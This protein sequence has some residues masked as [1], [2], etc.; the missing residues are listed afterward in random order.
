MHAI[1][2][3]QA[4]RCEAIL[5]R[6]ISTP[7]F[8]HPPFSSLYSI[9]SYTMKGFLFVSLSFLIF[10]TTYAQY[11]F[12]TCKSQVTSGQF[13]M[14][15][16]TDRNGNPLDPGSN[17][18]AIEGYQYSYCI[19]NCGDGSEYYS[20]DEFASQFTLWLLPWLTLLAQ[21]P[22]STKAL[23]TDPIVMLLSVGSPT[24][25][26]FSLIV[27]MFNRMWLRNKC[28]ELRRIHYIDEADTTLDNIAEVMYS[29]HQFPI[30][31]E[32]SGLLACTLAL[33]ENKNWWPHL[34][35]WF[36]AR[37][38]QMEASAWAQIAL[39]VLIYLIAVIPQAFADLGGNSQQKRSDP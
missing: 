25:A 30:E 38:R 20:F 21:I 39:S 23:W 22:Y 5:Q 36:V 24:T 18:S 17:T 1:F 9:L 26:L 15:G 34:R 14:A 3:L 16:T 33:E 6:R 4:Q 37:R 35:E 12:T 11:N 2:S 27:T 29:L 10:G 13:T 32:N 31:I 7:L 19:Q 28:E 8:Q